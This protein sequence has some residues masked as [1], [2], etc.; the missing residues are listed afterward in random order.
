MAD[1]P[2]SSNL[3][4]RLRAKAAKGGVIPIHDM[5]IEEAADEIERLRTTLEKAAEVLEHCR[6]SETP[7]AKECREAMTPRLQANGEPW[8]YRPGAVNLVNRR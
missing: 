4:A 2:Q 1:A 7:M 5:T 3:V 6:Y 8:D